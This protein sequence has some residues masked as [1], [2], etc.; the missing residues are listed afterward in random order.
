MLDTEIF[1]YIGKRVEFDNV[2]PSIDDIYTEFQESFE[3]HGC[4]EDV[5]EQMIDMYVRS[6]N[7]DGVRIEW[8]G[9]IHESR[10]RRITENAEIP[11]KTA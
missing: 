7:L 10:H 9:E 1:C 2:L 6:A 8:E 11:F 4:N 3:I 5:M